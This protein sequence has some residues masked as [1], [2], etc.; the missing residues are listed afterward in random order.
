MKKAVIVAGAL[1]W[2]ACSTTLVGATFRPD[3]PG[4]RPDSVSSDRAS[5]TSPGDAGETPRTET[6]PKFASGAVPIVAARDYLRRHEAPDFWALIPYYVPQTTGSSCSAA[7]VAMV[8]NALR[9]MPL[10][11]RD[12]L[13]TEAALLDANPDWAHATAADGEGVSFSEFETYLRRSL[14]AYGL[15]QAQVEAFRPEAAT[16]EA[17][18]RLRQILSENEASS[19]DLIVAVFNQGVLTGDTDVGHISPLAAYDRDSGRVLVM[20]VDRKWY[21]PYWVSDEKLLEALVHRS[22]EDP[23]RGGLVRVKRQDPTLALALN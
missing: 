21:V 18:A 3:N 16:P 14:A 23:E 2:A 4:S 7:S 15:G 20:D 1:V 8:L 17:L 10:L 6:S 13:V 19:Q 5:N 11:A 9:G 22:A 12:A